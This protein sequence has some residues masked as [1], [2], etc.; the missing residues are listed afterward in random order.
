M[1]FIS[2]FAISLL[3]APLSANEL[4]E[5]LERS[6][7]TLPGGYLKKVPIGEATKSNVFE[8]LGIPAREMELGDQLMWVYEERSEKLGLAGLSSVS[9]TQW[10][11]VFEGDTLIDVRLQGAQ[12]RRDSARERQDQVN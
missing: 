7:F 2:L 12:G 5:R 6:T 1:R 9:V 4:V 11:Y 10:I 8:A 3:A